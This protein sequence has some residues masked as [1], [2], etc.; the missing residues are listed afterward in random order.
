MIQ[1][2]GFEVEIFLYFSEVYTMYCQGCS[3]K[4]TSVGTHPKKLAIFK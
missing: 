1:T 4:K 2:G 3:A